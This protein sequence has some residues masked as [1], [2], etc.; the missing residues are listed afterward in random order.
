VYSAD[1]IIAMRANGHRASWINFAVFTCVCAVIVGVMGAY[2]FAALIVLIGTVPSL[3]K[4]YKKVPY[5]AA[6]GGDGS[7]SIHGDFG[8]D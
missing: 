8:G 4:A 5:I 3:I 1:E 7:G 6:S 2:V